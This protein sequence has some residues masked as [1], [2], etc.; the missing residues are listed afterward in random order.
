MSGFIGICEF[1]SQQ[2]LNEF[3]NE[4]YGVNSIMNSHPNSPGMS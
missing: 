3:L 1:I 4:I 2:A